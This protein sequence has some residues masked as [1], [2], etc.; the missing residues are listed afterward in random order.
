M[1]SGAP[2][3]SAGV[4][5]E[6][7]QFERNSWGSDDG[8][9]PETLIT[10]IRRFH[11]GELAESAVVD[12][13]RDVRL[14]VP[15]VAHLGEAGQNGHGVLVDK[16][17]E[18]SIV[19]VAAPDGRNVMPV[20]TSVEAM[21]AWNP[22]ARPVPTAATRVALA[23]AS[24]QTDLVILDPTSVTEFGIRRPALWA[25]AQAQPWTPGYVDGEVSAAF[26]DAAANVAEIAR[27]RIEAGD[28]GARLEHPEVLVRLWLAPGLDAGSLAA[29]LDTQQQRWAASEI[30]A[31]RVDSLAVKLHQA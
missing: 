8:R 24:E 17:Q 28:P 7:R 20:F 4:P 19:T 21:A 18:L 6:G 27:V 1:V 25:V 29:L 12:A 23:A 30:I 22:S 11:A 13:V 5:W 15:L 14:L 31:T 16:S 26:S 3:D 2:S 10:A 9:A